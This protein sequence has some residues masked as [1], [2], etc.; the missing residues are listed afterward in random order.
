MQTVQHLAV[1]KWVSLEVG[2]NAIRTRVLRVRTTPPPS[3]L[4]NLWPVLSCTLLRILKKTIGFQRS[5]VQK[6][7]SLEVDEKCNF[8]KALSTEMQFFSHF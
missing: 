4:V 3:W 1:Q 7:A 5:W 2:E 8:L 6:W